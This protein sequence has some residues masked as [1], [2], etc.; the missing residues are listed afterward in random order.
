MKEK[1]NIPKVIKTEEPLLP[2]LILDA[3]SKD[4]FRYLRKWQAQEERKTHNGKVVYLQGRM[5]RR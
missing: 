2:P 5:H 3:V 1:L 4:F